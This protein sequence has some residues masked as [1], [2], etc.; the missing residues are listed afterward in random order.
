MRNLV[1]RSGHSTSVILAGAIM[2]VPLAMVG[3][4]VMRPQPQLSPRAVVM[5]RDSL[6]LSPLWPGFDPRVTPLAMYDGSTTWLSGHPKVP[7]G[8]E[9]DAATGLL[10]FPGRHP[11]LSANSTIELDG[12]T[13]ATL[14]LD[15]RRSA[16]P[17]EWAGVAVHEAFH[18]FQQQRHPGWGPNE[19]QAFSYPVTRDTLLAWRRAETQEMA[20]ALSA[21]DLAGRSCHARRAMGYRAQRFSRMD[22]ASVLYEREAERFEG[23]ADYVESRALGRTPG[24]LAGYPPEAV[25]SRAYA[26]GSVQAALLD[27]LSPGWQRV[28]ERDDGSSLDELLSQAVSEG[29]DYCRAGSLSESALAAAAAAIDSL[30]R[31]RRDMRLSY[32]SQPGWTL[33]VEVATPGLLLQGFDPLNVVQLNDSE[34]LHRRVLRVADGTTRLEAFDRAVL[35]SGTET[36]P[37]FGGIRRVTVAGLGGRPAV[38]DSAGVL[39]VGAPGFTGRFEHAAMSWGHRLVRIELG[40]SQR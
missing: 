16:D 24:I 10:N 1:E 26:T 5:A 13:T 36:H 15:Q 19:A 25:R 23:L 37:L 21:A 7:T 17:R 11:E 18:A 9:V 40:G 30:H 31:R 4:G 29:D 35:T 20:L 34:V 14:L 33:V 12:T 6:A 32:L 38:K 8:F 28:M 22:S 39:L 27:S 3:C 2:S